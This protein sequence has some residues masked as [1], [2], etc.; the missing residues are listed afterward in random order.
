[1]AARAAKYYLRYDLQESS[2]NLGVDSSNRAQEYQIDMLIGWLN[3]LLGVGKESDTLWRSI[4]RQALLSFRA[5]I[6]REGINIGYF[7]QALMHHGGFKVDCSHIRHKIFQSNDLL[8]KHNFIE[9]S[10][11][12]SVYDPAFTDHYQSINNRLQTLSP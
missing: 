10:M 2:L 12:S 6:S 11:K 1:M 4:T 7:I 9:F 8:S 3:R 5:P